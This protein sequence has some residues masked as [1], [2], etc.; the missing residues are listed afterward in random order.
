MF[1]I[2]KNNKKKDRLSLL[3]PLPF[4]LENLIFIRTFKFV[5][6]TFLQLIVCVPPVSTF[7]FYCLVIVLVPF[8]EFSE[9]MILVQMVPTNNQ[10]PVTCS[11]LD[12]GEN[13]PLTLISFNYR[14]I[15]SN[16]HE[17][18]Y[19]LFRLLITEKI[20][21]HKSKSLRCQIY[22]TFITICFY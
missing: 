10:F 13:I 3:D 5:T 7:L 16:H 20:E 8:F 21:F 15:K 12:I 1:I 22:V 19:L 14:F 9:L 2:H 6:Y 18:V 4:S 11:S 17:N